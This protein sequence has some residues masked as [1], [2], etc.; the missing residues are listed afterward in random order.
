M[1]EQNDCQDSARKT[2]VVKRAIP[3]VI[4]NHKGLQLVTTMYSQ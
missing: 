4:L 3:H 2:V 1:I